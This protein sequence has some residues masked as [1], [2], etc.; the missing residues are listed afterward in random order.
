M[1]VPDRPTT[2]TP[3]SIDINDRVTTEEG[4]LCT[5]TDYY[6]DSPD[7]Y[8]SRPQRPEGPRLLV[9]RRH[10]DGAQLFRPES[11]VTLKT[12]KTSSSGPR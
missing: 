7:R 3:A 6:I 9:L 4:H 11:T 1:P 2:P 8:R 5:V 10:S 12:G